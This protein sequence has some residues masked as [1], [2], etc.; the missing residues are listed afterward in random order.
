MLNT[1][2]FAPTHHSVMSREHPRQRQN[3]HLSN[4]MQTF[5]TQTMQ[6]GVQVQLNGMKLVSRRSNF[7][8]KTK[9]IEENK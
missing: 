4:V 1:L 9:M 5:L 3:Y 2:Q 8:A 6:R 7:E